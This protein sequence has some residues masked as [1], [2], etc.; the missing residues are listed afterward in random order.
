MSAD[1][2]ADAELWDVHHTHLDLP[3]TAIAFES[4]TGE[5][6]I[7]VVNDAQP[8]NR[9]LEA[10]RALKER[11][12][13]LLL[14]PLQLFFDLGRRLF[15]DGPTAATTV[16][17]LIT[18]TGITLAFTPQTPQYVPPPV[19]A[20]PAHHHNMPTL[21]A[22]S[23]PTLHPARQPTIRATPSTQQSDPASRPT[24]TPGSATSKAASASTPAPAS[25][26]HTPSTPRKST[27]EPHASATSSPPTGTTSESPNAA[28]QATKTPTLLDVDLSL[29]K[30]KLQIK[31]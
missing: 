5:H 11:H 7:I 16:S 10:I 18:G 23:R 25:P 6:P 22:V 21:E 28:P 4:D 13:N 8:R 1:A 27:P 26:T 30:V 14:L 17:A 24:K 15:A 31:M 2:D 12:G 9:V 19:F 20:A 3:I 29:P